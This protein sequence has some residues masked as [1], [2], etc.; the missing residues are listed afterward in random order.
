MASSEIQNDERT[1]LLARPTTASSESS[2]SLSS[3]D[4]SSFSHNGRPQSL[5]SKVANDEEARIESPS[6]TTVSTTSASVGRIVSVLLIGSFI[7]NA[8]GSLLFATHPIIASEFNALHDSSWLMTS[9]ALA[10]AATQPMYGKLSDIYG[11]KTMLVLAYALFAIGMVLVGVGQSMSTLIAGRVISGAGSSGMTTLVSILITDLV[12][13]RDVATWRSY[14]NVVATT[15]RSIGGPLG[16]WLADTVG[17]RWSFLGQVPL[18]AIA[19]MLIG[20][21]L[22]SQT[23]PKSAQTTRGGKFARI[24]FVGATFLTLS[25][26]GLLFPLEIGGDRVA[27]S[28][29]TIIAFLVG[30]VISGLLFLAAEGWLAKEPIVPLSLLRQRDVMVSS[31]VMFFQSSAQV[32]LMFAVPLYFQISSGASNTVAGAHL[33]PAVVGNALGGI[34]SGAIISRTGRYK[35]LILVATLVSSTGYLLLILRWHGN[36]NWLESL[37]IFPGG[38]GMGIVQSALF[39]SVQAAIDPSFAAIAASTLYLTSSVGFLAGMAGVSAVLQGTLRYGLGHRLDDI[40]IEGEKKWKII[41]HA[42]ED[43]HYAG[44]AKEKI[45]K[46]VV[47]SYIDA[48]TWTHVLSLV[49][50]L[51]A[52]VGS[53]FL[54]QHKL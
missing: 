6:D 27:W 22:P 33:V 46:V 14:V 21:T 25:I 37:Y 13:L 23:Q 38:F 1:P 3:N 24:D 51:I 45:A 43:V 53:L 41:R 29:P 18:A 42:L 30:A 44:K 7:S 20:I 39:I 4:A 9:F 8:D 5:L 52:F 40:G 19:T 31:F 47:G 2:A 35:F 48:L 32:G 26:L 17:W 28:S 54:R 10:Q 49:C 34:I 15:G 36:T 11:R 16:G 12:P 50:S